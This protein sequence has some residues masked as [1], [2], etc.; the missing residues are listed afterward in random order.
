MKFKQYLIE[1]EEITQEQIDKIRRDCRIFINWCHAENITSPIYRGK[2][3]LPNAINIV[4]RRKDREP[5]NTRIPLQKLLDEL[6]SKQFHW[7]P[8]AEGVFTTSNLN[9]ASS[10]GVPNLFFPIRN[11]RY[12]WNTKERDLFVSQ[13]MCD[14]QDNL[15]FST[16]KNAHV[17]KNTNS[18]L[19]A[20][21][22]LIKL[23]DNC[24]DYDLDKAIAMKHEIMFDV[25]HYYLVNADQDYT[26]IDT[27]DKLEKLFKRIIG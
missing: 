17:W 1:K 7:K 4:K 18:K 25:N 20:S 8:R 2:S 3:Y 15:K 5:M 16:E 22:C 9:T 12:V 26:T 27:R 24:I 14:A 6:L 19:E 11:Y 13:D 23:A 10:Y 21:S